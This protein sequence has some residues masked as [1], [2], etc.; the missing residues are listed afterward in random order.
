MSKTAAARYLGLSRAVASDVLKQPAKDAELSA[1]VI[2][3]SQRYPRFGYRRV[4][5]WSDVGQSRIRRM[6][7]LL[8][9]ALL[10]RRPRRPRCGSDIRLPNAMHPNVV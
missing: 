2:E 6:W 5:A 10:R 9:L 8:G 4:S 7:S 3:I 1:R